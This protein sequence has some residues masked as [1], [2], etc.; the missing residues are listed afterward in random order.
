M[1]QTGE[2]ALAFPA[3]VT[4][5]AYTPSRTDAGRV[6]E[7]SNGSA[8]TITVPAVAVAGWRVGTLMTVFQQ[9]AGQVTIAGAVGVTLHSSGG[10]LKTAAQYSQISLRMRANDEWVVSGDTTA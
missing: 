8:V 6:L 9:G 2:E 3:Q 10:K 5:T 1:L 4:G 7:S